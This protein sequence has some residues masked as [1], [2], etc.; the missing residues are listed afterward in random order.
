MQFYVGDSRCE[1]IILGVKHNSRYRESL[2]HSGIDPASFDRLTLLR[3]LAE[4]SSINRTCPKRSLVLDTVLSC[5]FDDSTSPPTKVSSPDL[6]HAPRGPSK[7]LPNR[8]G[9]TRL[10]SLKPLQNPAF[11]ERAI[12]YQDTI[13]G[14]IHDRELKIAPDDPSVMYL[15]GANL[16]PSFYLRGLCDGCWDPNRNHNHPPLDDH[17]FDCLLLMA[18][19]NPCRNTRNGEECNSKRCM[20]G[21]DQQSGTAGP[22]RGTKRTMDGRV[23]TSDPRRIRHHESRS[24]R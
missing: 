9:H 18:R 13:T 12:R 22:E 2:Q 14:K 3:G 20:Y 16:C 4:G 8:V 1:H 17:Q 10:T 5:R 6:Q 11:R 7:V 21:Y 24:G 19:Q 23:E 15:Q